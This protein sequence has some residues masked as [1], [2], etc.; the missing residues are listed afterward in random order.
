MIVFFAMKIVKI[1]YLGNRVKCPICNKHYRKFLPYGYVI[2]RENALCPNC[3]SLERHRLLWLF[4]KE[5]TDF[6][7]KK[8]KFLHIAPEL[9]FIKYFRKLENLE[10]T[11][12]DLESPWADV[13]LNVENMP[14]SDESF[15][16]IMANHI[17]EHVENLDM[18]LKEIYRILKKDG[19]AI[20]ISPINSSREK[21]YEDKTITDPLE[22]E[23]HFGQ[24]DHLRVF[25]QDYAKILQRDGVEIFEDKFIETIKKEDIIRYSLADADN[26]NMETY[27]YGARKL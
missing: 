4:L 11:T 6:F 3:L 23:K 5:K 15:D 7:T 24:K 25:G 20:L 8:R 19:M 17:L 16:I 2:S 22:R 26:L 14:F 9:C 1:F 10:Y 13:Y 12:A 27:I 18:A 21:T